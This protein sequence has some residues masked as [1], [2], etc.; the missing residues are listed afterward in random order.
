M[1]SLT[2]VTQRK[3]ALDLIDFILQMALRHHFMV[4]LLKSEVLVSGLANDGV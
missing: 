1:R 2:L 4:I 3:H